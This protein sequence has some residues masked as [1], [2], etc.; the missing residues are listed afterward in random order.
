MNK[1]RRLF[2]ELDEAITRLK[3]MAESEGSGLV[4]DRHVRSAVRELERSRKGGKLDADRLVR[5]VVLITEAASD[6]H[7]R[8]D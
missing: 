1:K 3:R 6:R 8:R 4:R 7:L 5:A 2:G